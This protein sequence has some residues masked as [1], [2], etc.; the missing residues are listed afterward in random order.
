[1]VPALGAHA[2]VLLVDHGLLDW[3]AIG[4]MLRAATCSCV[5]RMS[6]A[7]VQRH[8]HR[9]ERRKIRHRRDRVLAVLQDALQNCGVSPQGITE[10]TYA[11]VLALVRFNYVAD[12][13][14]LG[15]HLANA[16]LS[17]F[18]QRCPDVAAFSFFV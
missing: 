13:A 3:L 16:C 17:E 4:S 6:T 11:D 7:A 12:T 14:N 9:H 1:M 18:S 5:S 10:E 8:M 2:F 15:A